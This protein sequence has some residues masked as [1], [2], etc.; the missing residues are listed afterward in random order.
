[1]EDQAEAP[2]SGRPVPDAAA[3]VEAGLEPDLDPEGYA[4][5]VVAAMAAFDSSAASVAQARRLV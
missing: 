2:A 3:D 4:V 5:D 1:V